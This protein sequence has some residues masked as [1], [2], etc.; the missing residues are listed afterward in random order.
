MIWINKYRRRWRTA[1]FLLLIIALTGPWSFDLINVPAEYPCSLPNYRLEGDFCGIPFSLLWTFPQIF[2]SFFT[3]VSR[4]LTGAKIPSDLSRRLLFSIWYL[5]PFL[6]FLT[7]WSLIS[8]RSHRS[9]FVV[10]SWGLAIGVAYHFWGMSFLARPHPELGN[11]WLYRGVW[12]YISVAIAALLLELS[13]LKTDHKTN[14]EIT[15]GD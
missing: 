12:L 2:G 1:V 11:I 8:R 15:I 3:V 13:M 14:Q 9:K 10:V 5:L 6:P 4:L 7:T